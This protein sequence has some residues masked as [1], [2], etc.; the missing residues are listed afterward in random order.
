MGV[1]GDS[2]A[3]PCFAGSSCPASL[4]AAVAKQLEAAAS[5]EAGQRTKMLNF[6]FYVPCFAG[7]REAALKQRSRAHVCAL[8]ACFAG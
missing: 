2:C 4:E 6:G 7:S 5:S 3:L 1:L 8:L